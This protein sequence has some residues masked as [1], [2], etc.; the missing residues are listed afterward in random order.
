MTGS[1]CISSQDVRDESSSIGLLKRKIDDTASRNRKLIAESHDLIEFCRL[2]N[3]N[4]AKS[5]EVLT[6]KIKGFSTILKND[7][8][9][10]VV[11]IANI[12]LVRILLDA[13]ADVNC[14]SIVTM[15]PL[16][17]AVYKK[18][19]DIV[20]LLIKEGASLE[21]RDSSGLTPQD[22]AQELKFAMPA[23]SENYPLSTHL[24]A[25]SKEAQ[26]E[27]E[28]T[29]EHHEIIKM[30]VSNMVT[31]S[32]RLSTSV[33]LSDLHMDAVLKYLVPTRNSDQNKFA[34][35]HLFYKTLEGHL[36]ATKNTFIEAS[37]EI[38]PYQALATCA[39]AALLYYE[40]L[41]TLLANKTDCYSLIGNFPLRIFNTASR[42][43]LA[44]LQRLLAEMN[45][46]CDVKGFSGETALYLAVLAD[47]VCAVDTLLEAGASCE[48]EYGPGNSIVHVALDGRK[49]QAAEALLRRKSFPCY[50]R[51]NSEGL[52]PLYRAAEIRADAVFCLL[53]KHLPILFG[54]TG[55]LSSDV[56]NQGQ[57]MEH[58]HTL[59]QGYEAIV[60]MLRNTKSFDD[61]LKREARA[62]AKPMIWSVSFEGVR[63][64]PR[65]IIEGFHTLVAA[66][67][68]DS[69]ERFCALALELDGTD[70]HPNFSLKIYGL[71][72]E[73][74]GLES[75]READ[76]NHLVIIL[77]SLFV[78][79]G[80]I[81]AETS[82][83]NTP[84]HIAADE[85]NFRMVYF[86]LLAGAGMN[87]GNKL[88]QTP[89][90]RA[91]GE[92]KIDACKVLIAHGAN[93]ASKD[94][95]GYTPLHYAASNL[96]KNIF[97]YLLKIGANFHEVTKTGNTALHL[98]AAF[99]CSDIN[100]QIEFCRWLVENKAAIDAQ[101]AK[102]NTPL[103]LAVFY[104]NTSLVGFFVEELLATGRKIGGLVNRYGQNLLHCACEPKKDKK[105][106][107]DDRHG[108]QTE[109]ESDVVVKS[110][111]VVRILLSLKESPEML[112]EED[113]FG[114]L[115][116]HGWCRFVGSDLELF[117]GVEDDIKEKCFFVPNN[118]GWTPLHIACFHN[119]IGILPALLGSKKIDVNGQIESK[120]K[121]AT[122]SAGKTALMITCELGHTKAFE[123]LLATNSLDYDLRDP[124]IGTALDWAC[125]FER[126]DLCKKLL[127]KY[128]KRLQVEHCV[129]LVRR[130]CQNNN[131]VLATYFSEKLPWKVLDKDGNTAL[132]IAAS[133]GF[134]DVIKQLLKHVSVLRKN[135]QIPNKALKTASQ[136][137]Q[138]KGFQEVVDIL[139]SY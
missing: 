100:K 46:G 24:T 92:K 41:N 51:S 134:S 99:S 81:D 61:Y 25:L 121:N 17:C 27:N 5:P 14:V 12:D 109:K 138:K 89:L 19:E 35:I 77:R 8:L 54:S 70:D 83:G 26:N 65:D 22:Y 1:S 106:G 57:S 113:R 15:T 28:R 126:V 136:L 53:L 96:S 120:E 125:E 137:A 124:I 122:A 68:T 31:P 116:F 64:P 101:N 86:L 133:Q 43:D 71:I 110:L 117:G 79:D 67:N 112:D 4:R 129:S 13:K 21:V 2:P 115:P 130:A 42:G 132:H 74:V 55:N 38:D 128:D 103:H 33:D 75:M 69:Y 10:S 50:Y 29:K 30:L 36:A 16:H 139:A 6:E 94:H 72:E 102:G 108:Q 45:N 63:I 39:A 23:Q 60:S 62:T 44:S 82:E 66:L 131:E 85:G 135:V 90:H 59:D 76:K 119:N 104:R 95:K 97:E 48:L 84:L 32:H 3:D 18:H 127:P 80:Y 58:S 34:R 73:V 7:L 118:A 87:K 49:M 114:N 88:K 40:R 78:L 107:T 47:D 105:I 52:V 98:A 20:K 56:V 11:F 93:I 91:C 9:N 123:L 37:T 111:A